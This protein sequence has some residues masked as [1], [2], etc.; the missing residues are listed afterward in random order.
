MCSP[1]IPD[2]V[3]EA[4][5]M[6]HHGSHSPQNCSVAHQTGRQHEVTPTATADINTTVTDR[7]LMLCSSYYGEADFWILH[8]NILG[9]NI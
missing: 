8:C 4:V 7:N 6:V 9:F 1:V 5:A 3:K 2:A